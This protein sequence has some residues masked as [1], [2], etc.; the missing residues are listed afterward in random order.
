ME[1]EVQDGDARLGPA[2]EAMDPD[3]LL[4]TSLGERTVCLA[5]LAPERVERLVLVVPQALPYDDP[6]V[7]AG[8]SDEER[9]EVFRFLRGEFCFECG[10]VGGGCQCWNDE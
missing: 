5:A 8:L 10:R 4:V 6:E 1:I 9:E 3:T 7:V 2:L